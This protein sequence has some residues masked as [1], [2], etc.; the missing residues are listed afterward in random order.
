MVKVYNGETI[1]E[2]EKEVDNFIEAIRKEKIDNKLIEKAL[3]LNKK[4]LISW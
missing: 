3:L 2:T 1:L 4:S